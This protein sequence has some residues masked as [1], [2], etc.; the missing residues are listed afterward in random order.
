MVTHKQMIENSDRGITVS[1]TL[2]WAI[3]VSIVSMVWW[4]GSTISELSTSQE[5]IST[6]LVRMEQRTDDR[7]DRNST[8]TA[9]LEGRVRSL[10]NLA[11]RLTANIEDLRRTLGS[12]QASQEETHKLLRDYLTSGP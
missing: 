10:E 3:L 11:N 2:G 12:I 9:Q 8:N 4:G 5:Q 1:K 7:I 6:E